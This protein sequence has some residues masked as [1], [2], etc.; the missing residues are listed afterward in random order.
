MKKWMLVTGI[1]AVIGLAQSAN[2]AVDIKV[3]SGPAT[4][5]VLAEV[6]SRFKKETG[7]GIIE[8]GRGDRG[9][10]ADHCERRT[11][12]CCDYPRPAD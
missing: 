5:G 9:V 12:R 10:E 2:A 3:I 11:V 1:A 4:A 8:T 6:A 7:Y